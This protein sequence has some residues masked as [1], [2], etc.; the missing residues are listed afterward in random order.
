MKFGH[1]FVN[2]PIFAA[3]ISIMLVIVRQDWGGVLASGRLGLR[4]RPA[5]AGAWRLHR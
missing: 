1:F 2:R 4:E 3:V 5:E